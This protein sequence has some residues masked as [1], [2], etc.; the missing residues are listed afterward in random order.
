MNYTR[1]I[2]EKQWLAEKKIL[3]GQ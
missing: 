2:W 3:R 1:F